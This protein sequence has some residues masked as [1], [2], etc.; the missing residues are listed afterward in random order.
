MT[1]GAM[2]GNYWTGRAVSRRAALRGLGMGAAGLAGA[3]LLGCRGGGSSRASNDVP[4]AAVT[5]AAASPTP[6]V[7]VAKYGGTLRAGEQGDT[8]GLDPHIS[9]GGSD[10]AYSWLMTDSLVKFNSKGQPDPTLSLAEK[11][12]VTDGV[13]ITFNL[14]PNV[15]FHDGSML[16]AQLIKRNLTRVLDP[17]TNSTASGAMSVIAAIETPDAKTVNVK[18]KSPNSAFLTLLGDRGGQVLANKYLDLPVI[19][20]GDK[21]IGSGPFRYD[22]WERDS[23][24]RVVK[25]PDYWRKTAAGG[26]LPYLDAIELK[27]IPDENVREANFQG[28]QVDMFQPGFSAVG[29]YEKSDK[30]QLAIFKGIHT[31]M[32]FTNTT[33]A[34][35]D[36]VRF[37]R[38]VSHAIDRKAENAALYFGRYIADDRPGPIPP[39]YNQI[40]SGNV[41]NA[42]TFDLAEAKKLLEASKYAKNPNFEQLSGTGAAAD[43]KNALYTDFMAKLGIKLTSTASRDTDPF[44]VKRVLPARTALLTMRA[45]PDGYLSEL[46]GNAGF[47]NPGRNAGSP[48]LQAMDKV[49]IDARSTYN[50][51]ERKAHYQKLATMG[52][53]FVVQAYSV[54]GTAYIVGSKRIGNLGDYFSFDGRPNWGGL[55]VNA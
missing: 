23:M 20:Q 11:W 6:A 37:R 24:V 43:Q 55:W 54:Y 3:A 14:R 33:V 47:Y 26:A 32:M 39:A 51:E 16:D 21:I 13:N 31:Q 35:M 53:D 18:L 42:P 29:N 36:D 12:E 30:S 50:P 44:Y 19:G 8:R 25:N 2:D 10:I 15:K 46:F 27:V 5:K 28:G 4:P 1:G 38:A 9:V 7:S 22:K 52:S 40:Y 17:K 45:D 49:L 41:S 34:P 48:E